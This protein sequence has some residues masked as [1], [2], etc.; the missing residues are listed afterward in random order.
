[1]AAV[2]SRD[3]PRVELVK[4]GY[5]I[6]IEAPTADYVRTLK[7]KNYDDMQT[8]HNYLSVYGLENPTAIA[9][10][11]LSYLARFNITPDA[12][13]Y[14]TALEQLSIEANSNRV[15]VAQARR[16]SQSVETIVATGGDLNKQCVYINDGDNPCDNCLELNGEEMK[17]TEFVDEGKLPGDRCLG[18]DNCLCILVPI[19]T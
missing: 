3:I 6:Y 14:Q 4:D 1:M 10:S 12:D 13:N 15:L 17:Y 16:A 9:N 18:G 8:I 19:E 2:S 7:S 11:Q 5:P